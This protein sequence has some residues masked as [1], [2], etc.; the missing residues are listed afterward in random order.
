MTSGVY[1][2]TAIS[3]TNHTFMNSDSNLDSRSP[4]NDPDKTQTLKLS[5]DLR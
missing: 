5:A 2:G 1:S 3:D 4:V